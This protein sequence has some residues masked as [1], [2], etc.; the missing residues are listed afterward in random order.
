MTDESADPRRI[1]SLPVHRGD[2]LTAFEAQERDRKPAVL[3]VVAPFSGRMR[4]RP[5]V[6]HGEPG[7]DELH[8]H[9][10]V[11][12][13]DPPSFPHVDETADELREADEYDVERHR[14]AHERAVAA[15]RE[16][17]AERLRE[18]L[19]LPV[20][21]GSENADGHEVTVSYLG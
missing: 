4:A 18:R 7:S 14:E 16:H 9:P 6:A 8:L 13:E 11:F 2:V 3:R 10:A 21:Q 5:H 15:W 20:D 1:R 17:V 12:V 19:T